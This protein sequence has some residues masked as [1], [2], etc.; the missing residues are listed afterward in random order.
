M[1]TM[2]VRVRLFAILRERAGCD[3]VEL[4][5]EEGATVADAIERLSRREPLADLFARMPMTL[6]VNR[7]YAAAETRLQAEDELALVPPISGGAGPHVR[8]TEEPLS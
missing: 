7:D 6:A 5:L 4:E 2:I 8:L 3:S 1:A